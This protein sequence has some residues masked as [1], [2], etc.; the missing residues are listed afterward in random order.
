MK[1]LESDE[2]FNRQKKD[3]PKV[4]TDE[5]ETEA[6]M[7]KVTLLYVPEKSKM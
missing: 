5:I 2:N 6:G 1:Y 7:E 3:R 4:T